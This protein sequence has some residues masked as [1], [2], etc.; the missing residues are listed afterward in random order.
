VRNLYHAYSHVP[1]L[2]G[3][4]FDL[5][6]GRVHGLIGQ[7]GAGK[8]TLIEILSG[9]IQP[10]SG[11]IIWEGQPIAHATPAE[12]TARGLAVVHQS[13]Q[14]FSNMTV[15]SNLVGLSRRLPRRRGV[16][17][18][19]ELNRR[20]LEILEPYGFDLDPDQLVG[21][22]DPASRK[23]VD[24]ARAL[25]LNPRF[26]I[27]DEPTVSFGPQASAMVIETLKRLRDRGLGLCYVS[28]RLDEVSEIADEVT[29]LRDGSVVHR[30]GGASRPADMAK[31]MSGD[32]ISV[33]LGSR[34]SSGAVGDRRSE[35]DE[36]GERRAAETE[37]SDQ[38]PFEGASVWMARTSVHPDTEVPIRRGEV[39]GL[40]G[41]VGSGASRFVRCLGGAEA[42]A[43][44]T[45]SAGSEE[46]TI[47]TIRDARRAG[48]AFIPADRKRRGIVP[49]LSVAKNISLASLARVT[50]FGL[51]QKKLLRQIASE[52]Q[53]SLS[54]KIASVDAEA[55]TLSGGN[56]QKVMIAR[57]LATGAE[58]L[59]IEEPTQGVD[60]AAR[61][62][63]HDLLRGFAA[64]GGTAVAA[65]TDVDELHLFC[66][67][68][69]VFRHGR[70]STVLVGDDMNS[71][72][73]MLA[74]VDAGDA[75]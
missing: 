16:L 44:L 5:V 31:A 3:I 51:Q 72:K 60:I 13:V 9:A 48:V 49:Q 59:A 42:R 32:A 6:A 43:M 64:A 26:L 69:A 17:D 66:D 19:R 56:Q 74:A 75:P 65:S 23:M 24:I 7:N 47:H 34:E 52:F 10:L 37:V 29:V 18:R 14:L 73:V 15:A 30:F 2:R 67:R 38:E 61:Q 27:L 25:A 1:V 12:A 54:I 50:R 58:I 62:Q 46:M 22:L 36:Q 70:L 53:Q 4:D 45:L 40:A 55:A 71:I 63:I 41:L 33:D 28:H 39:L 68:I 57:A 21:S 20:A 8:S 35:V 11:E